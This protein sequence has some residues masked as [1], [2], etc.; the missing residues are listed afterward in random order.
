MFEIKKDIPVPQNT[1]RGRRTHKYP[2]CEME[3]GDCFDI[4]AVLKEPRVIQINVHSLLRN[5]KKCKTVP[6]D[7]KVFTSSITEEK[8][9]RVWRLQ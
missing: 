9:V 6:S 5:Y 7:F 3:I 8:V 4:P 2:F 1:G